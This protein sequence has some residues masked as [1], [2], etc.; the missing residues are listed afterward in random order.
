MGEKG[1]EK[2]EVRGVYEFQGAEYHKW[3]GFK[4]EKF[5]PSQLWRFEV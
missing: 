3:G 2:V 5:I 1:M 4:Q